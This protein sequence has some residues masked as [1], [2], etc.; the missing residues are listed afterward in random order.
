[1][2]NREGLFLEEALICIA[3]TATLT[4]CVLSCMNLVL[5][6]DKQMRKFE[7]EINQ[8]WE[9]IFAELKECEACPVNEETE[10][11]AS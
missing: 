9:E 8:S 2:K 1:M 3:V 7:E 6:G 11:E 5:Q 10:S 4:L